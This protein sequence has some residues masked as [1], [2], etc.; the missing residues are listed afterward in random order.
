[1]NRTDEKS[2]KI[3]GKQILLE[4]EGLLQDLGEYLY[5]VGK[6]VYVKVKVA[7]SDKDKKADGDDPVEPDMP[8]KLD[9]PT[10]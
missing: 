2:D 8:A 1:M 4:I 5:Q 10:D 3:T 6:T 7:L 9:K